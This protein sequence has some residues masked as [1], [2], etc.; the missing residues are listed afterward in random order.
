M[1]TRG[2]QMAEAEH[3]ARLAAVK[4]GYE[5]EIERLTRELDGANA[6]NDRLARELAGAQR[7][8]KRYRWLRDVWFIR[9]EAFPEELREGC[10]SAAHFDAAIDAALS[11]SPQAADGA[12]QVF[13]W[14]VERPGPNGVIWA[15]ANMHWTDDATDACW[16]AR[17]QDAELFQ[18][19]LGGNSTV[20]Q[21]VFIYIASPPAADGAEDNSA[22]CSGDDDDT[23]HRA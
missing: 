17:K 13:V 5:R 23:T 18:F 22:A 4:A 20:T 12:A 10:A 15:T 3:A 21:H 16:F 11:A 7:D 19:N 6:E 8:A 2:M 9:G 1:D 14:L